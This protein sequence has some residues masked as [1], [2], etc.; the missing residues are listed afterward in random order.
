[1]NALRSKKTTIIG[2]CFIVFGFAALIVTI[3][4]NNQTEFVPSAYAQNI[5][6]ECKTDMHCAVDSLNKL[7]KVNNEQVLVVFSELIEKYDQ[8]EYPCHE[9]SHHLGMW[10]VGHTS[11]EKS[12]EIA[13]QMCGGGI[14]H[15]I[16]QNYLALENFHNQTPE[17]IDIDLCP[18]DENPYSIFR[19]QC[20]HGIGHGLTVLY[21]YDVVSAVQRCDEF[22]TGFEQISCSKG[23]FMENVGQFFEYKQGNFDESDIYYPCNKTEIKYAPSCYHY[24]SSMILLKNEF[25]VEKSFEDCKRIIPEEISDYCIHGIG[26]QLSD[27]MRGSVARA[28]ILCQADEQIKENTSMCLRG[29]VM[30]LINRNSDMS[31]GFEFCNIIDNDYK[32]D[33]YDALGKWSLMIRQ[34]HN[35]R[36]NEC[37]KSENDFYEDICMNASLDDINLL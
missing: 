14:F 6:D 7:H 26:R 5:L 2:F 18:K 12:L 10:L 1:M 11:L 36:K 15:G 31:K 37:G 32:K 4:Y 17:Q 13:K 22:A 27:Q 23:V 20:L 16:F 19:W 28:Q 25:D 29:M 35:N 34:E 24:Q 33:C 21:D 3:N 8:S 9:T 30:T